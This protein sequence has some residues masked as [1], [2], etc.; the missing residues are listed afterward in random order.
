MELLDRLLSL[1]NS[2]TKLVT[3]EDLNYYSFHSVL[4]LSLSSCMHLFH[5]PYKAPLFFMCQQPSMP[6]VLKFICARKRMSMCTLAHEQ[7]SLCMYKVCQHK[8]PFCLWECCFFKLF[9][10]QGP[11]QIL[12]LTAC[13]GRKWFTQSLQCTPSPF[14]LK[15]GVCVIFPVS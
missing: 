2:V 6:C 11:F 1:W 7:W 9:R 13:M 8:L 14:C 12:Y 10:P 3:T 4:C 15:R 5:L